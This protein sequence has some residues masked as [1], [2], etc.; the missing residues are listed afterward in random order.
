MK[1]RD[2]SGLEDR[3]EAEDVVHVLWTTLGQAF[4]TPQRPQDAAMRELLDEETL[5]ESFES[6]DA[7]RVKDDLAE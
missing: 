7:A 5:L 2:R 6:D 1:L 3:L 4:E